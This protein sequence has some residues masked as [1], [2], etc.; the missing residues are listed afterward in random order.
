M[1]SPVALESTVIAHGLPHPENVDTALRLE[2]IVR[3][4]GSVPQTIGLVDGTVHIGLTESHIRH[5]ATADD[6][7]KVSLRDLPPIAARSVDGATTVAATMHLAHRAG[8]TVM[9][10]GGIGGVHR[11]VGTQPTWDVS[12]DLEALRRLPMTVI[13]SGPKSILDL[14]ATR[15]RLE[16]YGVTVIGYQTDEMPAFYCASSETPVDVRCDTPTAVAEIIR[17]RN[18]LDLPSAILV[19]VPPPSES[20]LPRPVLEPVI[21]RALSD[22]ADRNLRAAEVTPFLLSRLREINGQ[23]IVETN[24]ALLRRNARVAARIAQALP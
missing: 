8:I 1:P 18:R 20:A 5:L 16:S 17:Q 12:A 19:T 11:T 2:E 9:A 6:V 13:C 14:R 4:E 21:E 23:R 15:E 3:A 22:A 24:R 10:T 7:A